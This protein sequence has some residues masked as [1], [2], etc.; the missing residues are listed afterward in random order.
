[1]LGRVRCLA[2]D[3]QGGVAVGYQDG[4]VLHWNVETE[5]VGA[6]LSWSAILIMHACSQVFWEISAHS[7]AV[8]CAAVDKAN[9]LEVCSPHR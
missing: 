1:M 3:G 5:Q 7:K 8:L 4:S 2:S 6:P 9:G